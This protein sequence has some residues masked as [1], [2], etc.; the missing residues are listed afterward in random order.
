M[1]ALLVVAVL[2]LGA[3]AIVSAQDDL[4]F[5]VGEGPF[6]WSDLDAFNEMDFAGEEVVFFGPWLRTEGEA[7]EKIVQYF[8][9]ATGANVVYV[10]SDSFEQQIIVDIQ[11]GNPPNLAAFPQP[12]LAANAA[13]IGGLVPLSDDVKQYVLD[14]YAAGQSW[15]DLGTY[16]DEMGDPQFYSIFYNVNLKS[17]VWYVSDEF[18]ENGYEIPQTWDEL[19]ALSEQMAE[20]GTTPWCIGIGSQAA[21]GWP[22][23]DWVEDIM[24]RTVEGSVY[25]QWVTNEIPFTDDRVKNAIEL[26]GLFAKDPRFVNGGP[27]AVVTTDFRD[28][29]AGLFT[30]PPQCYMHRQASFIAANFPEGVEVGVD[31]DFFYFPPIDEAL[32]N[33]VLGAGTLVAVTKD[34]PATQA[35]LEFLLTPLAHELWAAQGGFLTPLKTIN[36]DSYQTPTLQKQ[37][38]ILLNAD[39][40]RFDGSD[41]MPGAI[42]AGAFWTAM[43]DYTGG[44]S[45]DD[46][47]EAVQ[48]A[49]DDIK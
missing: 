38:E 44:A 21:T 41:L 31:A 37:G 12:G 34:S 43:V 45:V 14:N 36:I 47:T 16:A 35:F 9:D 8:N 20:D 23:T 6:T 15:V 33:P 24:L 48:K 2:M 46:V 22:A 13:S 42:G 29:P 40:F 49:W 26:Y 27:D 7:V 4:V 1:L 11:G 3:V 28:S 18:A 5:P 17:I 25:D 19:V 32:G 39:V 30:T 10:G